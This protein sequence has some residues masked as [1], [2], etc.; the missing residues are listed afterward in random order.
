LAACSIERLGA[1]SRFTANV[2]LYNAFNAAWV[3]GQFEVYGPQWRQPSLILPGRLL[4]VSGS[5][6]F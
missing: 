1:A 6:D 4:Q 3:Q 5:F 2:D